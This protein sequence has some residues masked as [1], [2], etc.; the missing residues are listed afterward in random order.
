MRKVHVSFLILF[1]T[2]ISISAQELAL[3]REGGQFGYIDK[4]GA[5]VI[6]PQFSKAKSFSEGRAAA[7]QDKKWGFIDTSGKWA[8]QPDYDKVKYF[9]SGYALVLKDDQWNYIDTSGKAL[10]TVSTEKY[11]DFE[12]GVAF[13]RQGEKIGLIGTDGKVILAPTFDAIKK[14]RNDHAKVRQGEQWGMIDKAGKLVIPAEYEELGNT[15]STS[16]VFGKK[17]GAFGII[18]N[19]TFNPIEGADK[20]WNFHGNSSLTYARKNKKI[21]YVNSKGEWVIEPKFDKAKAF[22]N[23]MAPV[24][25]GKTWGFI[26]EKGETVIDFQYRDAEVFADNGLAPVKEKQWGFIDTSG[27]LVI[28]M[29]YDI[30]AGL[31]FLSGDNAKGFIGDLARLK[32]KK[33]WGFF[34]EKGELL[35]NKWYENAEPFVKN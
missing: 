35:G 3:V 34:N 9:N 22:S 11:F 20:V 21:G 13:I 26:N 18:Q 24:A 8:I 17:G 15:F 29:Q 12:G 23:G 1:L 14:F 7:E 31:A 6:E 25:N 10:E 19:G 30:T 33:G 28:P 5:Y 16:G 2:V 27:S 32:S 4:S